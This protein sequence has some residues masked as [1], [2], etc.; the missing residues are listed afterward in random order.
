MI[1]DG[2]THDREAEDEEG[3]YTFF[4]SWESCSHPANRQFRL[5]VHRMLI[6]RDRG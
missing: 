1:K 6:E 5:D 4:A 2:E 3:K